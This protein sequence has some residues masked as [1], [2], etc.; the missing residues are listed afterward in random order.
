MQR[1][2]FIRDQTWLL[3]DHQFKESD[4]CLLVWNRVSSGQVG[5][6]VNCRPQVRQSYA[7]WATLFTRTIG[8]HVVTDFQQ[9]I[10]VLEAFFAVAQSTRVAIINDQCSATKV[11]AIDHS[12][13]V[14]TVAHRDQG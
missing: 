4:G 6:T 10:D 8:D 2:G 5:I 13:Q 9:L 3:F 11:F 1:G 12:P 14:T 7:A